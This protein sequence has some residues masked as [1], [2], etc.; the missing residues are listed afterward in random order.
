MSADLISNMAVF[1]RYIPFGVRSCWYAPRSITAEIRV[2][3]PAPVVYVIVSASPSPNTASISSATPIYFAF[4]CF[5]GFSASGFSR[6]I[7]CGL[8]SVAGTALP[9]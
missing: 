4:I 2:E 8:S 7:I 1:I 6:V 5:A 3:T 9:Q